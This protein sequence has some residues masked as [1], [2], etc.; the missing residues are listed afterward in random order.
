VE[1]CKL[2][3]DAN[4]RDA[5]ETPAENLSLNQ[6]GLWAGDIPNHNSRLMLYVLVPKRMIKKDNLKDFQELFMFTALL[7]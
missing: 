4:S 1:S 2:D 3:F 7:F 5:N 6:P